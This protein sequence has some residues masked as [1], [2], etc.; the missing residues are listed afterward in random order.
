[1]YPRKVY[2]YGGP[3]KRLRPELI[4]NNGQSTIIVRSLRWFALVAVWYSIIILYYY[5]D[6]EFLIYFI[7]RRTRSFITF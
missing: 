3:V 6:Q 4:I 5:I 1:M 7:R 2:D